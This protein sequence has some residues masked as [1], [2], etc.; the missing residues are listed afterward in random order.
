[1]SDTVYYSPAAFMPVLTK[2]L[3][4][5]LPVPVGEE[6]KPLADK[7]L[8]EKIADGLSVMDKPVLRFLSP[9]ISTSI[10]SL[11]QARNWKHSLWNWNSLFLSGCPSCLSKAVTICKK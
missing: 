11:C 2:A 5:G 10:S 7:K 3:G 6:P 1:M 8:M 4:N 9:A